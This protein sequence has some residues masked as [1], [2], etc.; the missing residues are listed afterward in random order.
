M[1]AMECDSSKPGLQIKRS[2][3]KE[4]VKRFKRIRVIESDEDKDCDGDIKMKE[5]FQSGDGFQ[6]P[7]LEKSD[8]LKSQYPT[9]VENGVNKVPKPPVKVQETESVLKFKTQT[10]TSIMNFFKKPTVKK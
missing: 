6:I 10:Q 1:E 4:D 7:K 3:S 5:S 9:C 2:Y 8:N